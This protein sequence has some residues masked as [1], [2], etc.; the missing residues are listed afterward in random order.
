MRMESSRDSPLNSEEVAASRTEPVVNPRIWHAARWERNVRELGW[1]KYSIA[2]LWDRKDF[3]NRDPSRDF[4]M[5]RIRLD[6]ATSLSRSGRSNCCAK[7]VWYGM[8]SPTERSRYGRFSS[9]GSVSNFSHAISV[10]LAILI[11]SYQKR[12]YTTN[13]SQVEEPTLSTEAFFKNNTIPQSNFYSS[14]GLAPEVPDVLKQASISRLTGCF[15][16]LLK[17]P[18]IPSFRCRRLFYLKPSA[19][20][21]YLLNFSAFG[22]I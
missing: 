10:N 9:S 14:W 4:A 20:F 11:I 7:S 17:A 22:I 19:F 2:R 5:N 15:R 3:R 8:L 12:D 6:S 16:S 1:E 13:P 18:Q 21:V